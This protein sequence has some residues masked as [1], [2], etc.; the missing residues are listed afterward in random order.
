PRA[1]SHPR[2]LSCPTRRSSDLVH[3]AGKHEINPGNAM[4]SAFADH[5]RLKFFLDRLQFFLVHGADLSHSESNISLCDKL[6]VIL[7]ENL[8]DRKSTRLN[9]SHVSISC[10]V[11]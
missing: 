2:L 7:I 11:F 1:C 4:T 10:A 9:S 3:N 8:L 6:L 5:E